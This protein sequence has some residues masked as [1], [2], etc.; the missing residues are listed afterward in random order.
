MTK[1]LAPAGLAA[2]LMACANVDRQDIAVDEQFATEGEAIAAQLGYYSPP[3]A[4]QRMG[5]GAAPTAPVPGQA[6]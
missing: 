2:M 5:A 1:W 3:R 4:T 6:P